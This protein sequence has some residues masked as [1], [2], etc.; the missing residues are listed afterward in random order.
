M[1]EPF[2]VNP[3]KPFKSKRGKMT[4][5]H[6]KKKARKSNPIG[7][8]LITVGGNP[9]QYFHRRN[10]AMATS[11]KGVMN[12]Q[13]WGPLAITGGLSAVAAGVAP[14]MIARMVG[15]DNPWIMLGLRLG[16]AFG[17]GVLVGRYVSQEHGKVW[18][19]VGTSLVA[20]DLLKQYVIA[21]FFPQLGLSGDADNGFEYQGYV[22]ADNSQMNAFPN[23]MNAYPDHGGMQAF[24]LGSYPYDGSYGGYATAT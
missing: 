8:T 3:P 12:V 1:R 19:V 9:M 15:I 23:Q 21:Q 16:V 11:L 7:E 2:L 4:V 22:E 10:P 20:Y 18:A 17:G 5:H 24:P 6:R 13:S 14:G